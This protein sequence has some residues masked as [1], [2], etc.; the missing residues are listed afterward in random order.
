MGI[1]KR[2]LILLLAFSLQSS[3]VPGLQTFLSAHE[4][5]SFLDTG[6][7][8]TITP[9]SII[10]EAS[11]L[12][13]GGVR[14]YDQGNWVLAKK[15]FTL[16][17]QTLTR[18]NEEDLLDALQQE[19]NNLFSSICLFQVRVRNLLYGFSAAIDDIGTET[20]PF[21]LVFNHRVEKWLEYYVTRDRDYFARKLYESG[22]YCKMMKEIFRK[23]GI[24][25][26]LVYVALVES[27][28][29]PYAYSRAHAAG[30]WQFISYTGSLFGLNRNHWIDER[31]DVEKSTLA[32]AEFLKILYN[33]FGSWLLALAAYNCGPNRV[34]QAIRD[35][36][37]T[38]F[39]LLSLPVETQ[40]FVPKVLAAIM[41]ARDPES[42][43]FSRELEAL[44]TYDEVQI[45]GCVDLGVVAKCCGVSIEEIM[46]LN[47]ELTRACT[48]DSTDTYTLKIPK[49]TEET[50]WRNFLELP[51]S[52]RYLSSE[53]IARRKGWWIVYKIKKGDTLGRIAKKFGTT[54]EKIRQWN[55]SIRNT[56]YIYPGCTLKIFK[57]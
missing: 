49:G 52:R 33:E 45:Q 1:R 20:Y 2:F 41:I 8:P 32:A 39:W 38:D 10:E 12:Y 19:Y 18:I 26:D 3:F 44:H 7:G 21:P 22:K 54:V 50:F 57:R 42:Y 53:E 35:Q 55:P 29:N 16:A 11:R 31:R 25:P 15:N 36:G 5:I 30:I 28:F 4:T 56:R 47:P 48:P 24:P 9:Q 23:K 13:E 6:S 46:I 51:E 40:E 34:K 37:T 43:G 27:G 17:L 14:E